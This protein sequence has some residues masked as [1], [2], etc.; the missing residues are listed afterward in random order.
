MSGESLTRQVLLRVP[1]KQLEELEKIA[2]ERRMKNV[3]TLLY[4]LI[5]NELISNDNR[6]N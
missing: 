1:V 5:E 2:E 4:R 3:Q 6:T